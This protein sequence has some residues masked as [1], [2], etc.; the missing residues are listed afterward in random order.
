M[1]LA[2]KSTHPIH[3]DEGH[4]RQPLDKNDRSWKAFEFF[5]PE[6]DEEV[7]MASDLMKAMFERTGPTETRDDAQ[8]TGKG[9]PQVAPQAGTK[10]GPSRDQ[11][12]IM[13]HLVSEQRLTELMDVLER[14]NRTKF[15]D[16]VLAPLLNAG[17]VEMT[18]PDKP[19]SSKQKYRLTENGRKILKGNRE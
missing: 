7:D 5:I 11:V 6:L 13:E 2:L 17:F 19:R 14:K 4:Q 8:V 16:Q 15:R 18:I 10:S 3:H 1:P 9:T 12:R